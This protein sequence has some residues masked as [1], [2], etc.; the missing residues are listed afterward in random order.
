MVY[1]IKKGHVDMVRGPVR[2]M[3]CELGAAYAHSFL[4]H[5]V[6]TYQLSE[7]D[8]MQMYSAVYA[9]PGK[10]KNAGN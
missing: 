4:E 8:I 3:L 10:T 9:G 5:T 6:Q 2:E 1:G 7:E